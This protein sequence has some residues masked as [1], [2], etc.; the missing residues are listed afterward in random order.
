MRVKLLYVPR[1]YKETLDLNKDFGYSSKH[2]MFPPLGL[3]TIT[4]YLKQNGIKVS[5]DD[6]NIK[7]FTHNLQKKKKIKIWLFQDKERIINYLKTGKDDELLSETEK[8]LKLTKIKG[9]DI[10]GFSIV[11]DF[12]FSAVSSTILLAKLIK[13]ITGAYTVVGGIFTARPVP[14]FSLLNFP[15]IDFLCLGN[16]FS[17]LD[18]V[19]GLE[20][21][22]L[23]EIKID[24][25]FWNNRIGKKLRLG[26][27]TKFGVSENWIERKNID[28]IRPV[29]NFDGLPLEMYKFEIKDDGT[30][31]KVLLLPY[32]FTFGCPMGCAFCPN[33]VR[34]MIKAKSPEKVKDEIEKLSK[35][36]NTKFFVFLND[37]M[38]FSYQ[39]AKKLALELKKLEVYWTDCVSFHFMDKKLLSLLREAGGVRLVWGVES[40]SPRILRLIGKKLE[41]K[42]VEKLIKFSYSLGI[43]NEVNLMVGFPQEREEDFQKTLNF[44]KRIGKYVGYFQVTKFML[45]ESKMLFN[46]KKY[47]ICNIRDNV[48]KIEDERIFPRKFDE[49]NGLK[50]EEKVKQIN[51]FDKKN[52][53]CY[54]NI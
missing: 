49:I 14:E 36:Y 34:P 50:W 17:L 40:A 2:P 28:E 47:G 41:I 39:Y 45:L 23:N 11:D 12:N 48:T 25:L 10:F 22:N 46:P 4:S 7:V 44:V 51:E 19:K 31:K 27:P 54:Q 35:K 16:H 29:P 8:I 53:R 6:L 37:I 20:N 5:Q 52:K 13:E 30:K 32:S 24:K 1:I 38:N 33:S 42:K 3:A 43:W 18:L 15:F 26:N 21:G 9:F